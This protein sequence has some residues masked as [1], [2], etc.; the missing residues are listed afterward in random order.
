MAKEIDNNKAPSFTGDWGK[1]VGTWK[2]EKEKQRTHFYT[3]S[4][5]LS[6]RVDNESDIA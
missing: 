5:L 6:L 4:A 2:N 1:D 3:Q